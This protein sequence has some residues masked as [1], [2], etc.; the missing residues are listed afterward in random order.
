MAAERAAA[1]DTIHYGQA[2][3]L[4][5]P[6]PPIERERVQAAIVAAEQ[7]TS[8]E[9]RVLVLRASVDAPVAEAR[10]QF[11]RLGMSAT[12]ERNGVLILLAPRSHAYAVIGDLGIHER[13]GDA[14]WQELAAAMGEAFKRGDFTAGLVLGVERAGEL[15][16]AHFPRRPDDR[17]ELPDS[18]E[19]V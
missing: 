17:N 18:M 15:L 2:M 6:L 19:V 1:G 14:F 13:C 16:A 5:S 11:D 3:N 12:A 10:R 4:F 7:R 8:G 9:I